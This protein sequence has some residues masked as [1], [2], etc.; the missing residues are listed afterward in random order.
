F[1]S[2]KSVDLKV[3]PIHHRLEQRVRTHILL[4]MLG[5][6][7]EFHMRLALAP[8]LFDEDDPVAAQAARVSVVAPPQRSPSARRKAAAKLT[9]DD[10]PVHSFR[11]LLSDLATI[12]KNRIV[13]ATAQPVPF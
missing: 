10:A 4:C 11:T 7:V 13:P 3:R 8:M 12:A 2:L 5:C 9:A 6:Y 1:R